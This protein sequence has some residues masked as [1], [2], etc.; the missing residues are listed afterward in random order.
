MLTILAIYAGCTS[1]PEIANF[2]AKVVKMYE[3]S[4]RM[5]FCGQKKCPSR[6]IDKEQS[7]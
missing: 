1:L 7:D 3:I 5:F 2:G 6:L 4:K